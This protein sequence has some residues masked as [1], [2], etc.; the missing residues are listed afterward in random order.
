MSSVKF[1]DEKRQELINK[2]LNTYDMEELFDILEIEI[3]EVVESTLKTLNDEQIFKI[4][5]E[6]EL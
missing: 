3:Y 5:T 2:I 4:I 1:S 6:G